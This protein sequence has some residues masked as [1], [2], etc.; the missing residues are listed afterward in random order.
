GAATASRPRCCA[1]RFPGRRMHRR[2]SLLRSRGA[3]CPVCFDSAPTPTALFLT[4][5][6]AGSAG[7]APPAARRSLSAMD[8]T[9]RPR[10]AADERIVRPFLR[11]IHSER[12][13][14]LGRIEHPLEHPA[15]VAERH[16]RF[17][18]LLTYVPGDGECEILTLHATE[19]GQ[20]VGTALI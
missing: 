2:K 16:G 1:R 18:G 14:R 20:G 11:E 17:A 15:L 13:A 6:G 12:V 3:H 4:L 7:G 19:R 10:T 8:I 5:G 9:V